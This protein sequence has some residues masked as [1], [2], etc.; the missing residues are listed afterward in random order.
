M[1]RSN[2]IT[3]EVVEVPP[4]EEEKTQIPTALII[5]GAVALLGAVVYSFRKR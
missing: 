1:A 5:L 3:I 4:P 2:T